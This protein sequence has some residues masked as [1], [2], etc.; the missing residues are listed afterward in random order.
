MSYTKTTWS[1]GDV[2]TAEKLNNIESGVENAG[3]FIVN[4][5]EGVLNKTWQEI[6]NA[7]NNNI[8]AY[9]IIKD[10]INDVGF[11][12]ITQVHFD[13]TTSKYYVNSDF[14]QY[15]ADSASDYPNTGN[16]R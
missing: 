1:D 12:L 14:S 4:A 6:Y 15:T 8:P 13:N 9:L 10:D 2:I 5:N 16:D 7:L 11:Y 3:I